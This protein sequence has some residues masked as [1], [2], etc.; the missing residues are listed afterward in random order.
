[1]K[2]RRFSRFLFFGAMILTGI[3]QVNAQYTIQGTVVESDTGVAVEFAT[4]QLLTGSANTFVGYGVTDAKGTFNIKGNRTDSLKIV[5]SSIGFEKYEQSVK[6][7]DV[8]TIRLA[9]DPF[10][11]EEVVVRAGRVWNRSDTIVYDVDRFRTLQDRTLKD[12]LQKLPGIDVNEQGRISYQGKDISN[13]YIEGMDPVGGRYNQITNNL[14]AETVQAVQVMENHQPIKMLEDLVAS[15]DIA[16]NL[17]LKAEFQAVWMFTLEGG[18]GINP[19]L[20]YTSDN[21][22]RLSRTNQSITTY[23]GNN[24]GND[25]TFEQSVLG[26]RRNSLFEVPAALSYLSMPSIMAPLKKERLLFNDVHSFSTNRI[27][28]LN[29]TTK[30]R[31]SANYTHDERKQERGSETI[32]YQLEDTI[33]IEEL[34]HTKLFSD[35]ASFN[36]HIDNNAADKLLTNNF[37]VY[38]KW[39]RGVSDFTGDLMGNPT[40]SQRL[41]SSTF[42]ASNDFRTLWGKEDNRYEIRSFL[43]YDHQ[44]EEIKTDLIQQNTLLNRLYTDNSF[45]ITRQTEYFI[46]QFNVG[47]TGDL[48]NLHNGFTPYASPNFQWNKDKLQT[49]FAFP[50]VWTHYSGAD[51]SRFSVRPSANLIYKPNYAWRFTLSARYREQYGDILNFTPEPYYSDYR[52]MIRLPEQLPIQKVQN[53]MLYGEYKKTASEFFTSLSLSCMQSQNSHSYEQ[54]AADGYISVIPW[55]LSNRSTTWRTAA[56]ISK[57]F[58]DIRLN[59]SLSTQL[60]QSKGEQFSQGERLPFQSN[61]INMEPKLNWTYWTNFIIDYQATFNLTSSKIGNRE[62]SPLWSIVQKLQLSYVLSSFETNFSTEHYYNEV[63]NSTPVNNYF[64]DLSFRLKLNKWRFSLDMNNL[65]DKRQYGYTEYSEIRSY[66][67]WINIRGREFLLG[68]QCRF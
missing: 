58:Y 48:N 47:F 53:Y 56:T 31:I 17:R 32:Y 64:V 36:I 23:K 15:E 55:A 52:N 2:N 43:R 35:D 42:G 57:G 51:F 40:T 21:A 4:V 6:P 33:R 12:V 30:M 67:S 60:N 14:R 63:N 29:E 5:I 59:T 49:S 26:A 22:I 20:W 50:A 24:T 39:N 65:L 16:I 66:S 62:L 8:L 7:G 44:P 13:F 11:L 34:S 18:I 46:P 27:S 68:V 9:A 37:N 25:V 41:L 54:T 28:M 3:V 45:S 1:M 19:I 61:R 38:G 10:V